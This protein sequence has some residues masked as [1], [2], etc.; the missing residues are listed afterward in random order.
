M[1]YYFIPN[2]TTIIKNK[3]QK[4]RNVGEDVERSEPSNTAGGK[5]K[6]YSCC[7]KTV[8]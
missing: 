4:I 3:E 8:W 1:S 7:G 6:W 5:V 2:R